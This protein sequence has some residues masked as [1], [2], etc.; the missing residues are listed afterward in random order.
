MLCLAAMIQ[1]KTAFPN[2]VKAFFEM[3]NWSHFWHDEVDRCIVIIIVAV[4][5]ALAVIVSVEVA[6]S[7]Q[8][9]EI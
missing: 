2:A 1:G 5:I 3:R 8:L 6:W 7:Q 4:R 9:Y